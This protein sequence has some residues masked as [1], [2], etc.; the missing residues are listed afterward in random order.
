MLLRQSVFVNTVYHI[1]NNNCIRTGWPRRLIVCSFWFVF[2][3][4]SVLKIIDLFTASVV[5]IFLV[6][7]LPSGFQIII[8]EWLMIFISLNLTRESPDLPALQ[9]D[10]E[11]K[12]LNVPPKP[13]IFPCML[14]LLFLWVLLLRN[15]LII[16]FLELTYVLRN[17]FSF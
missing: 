5:K 17:S 11:S 1:I 12:V 16:S 13:H 6:I 4:I 10:C 3:Y 2:V 7:L 9:T 8:N 15:V 14:S